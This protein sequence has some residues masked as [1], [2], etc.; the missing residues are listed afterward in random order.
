M[1]AGEDDVSPIDEH[2]ARH[3]L[4]SPVSGVLLAEEAARPS[5]S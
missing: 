4:A 1:A 2:Y 5:G 3:F